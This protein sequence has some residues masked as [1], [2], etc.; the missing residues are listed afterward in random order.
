MSRRFWSLK[1]C[2][3]EFERLS[4]WKSIT[5]V[6]KPSGNAKKRTKNHEDGR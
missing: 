2:L 3:Q 6:S 4:Q 5:C 1:L